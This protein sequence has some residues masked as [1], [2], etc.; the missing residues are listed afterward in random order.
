MQLVQPHRP[1]PV[2]PFFSNPRPRP[3]GGSG[4]LR[5]SAGALTALPNQA[6]S[7]LVMVGQAEPAGVTR[8]LLQGSDTVQ[9]SVIFGRRITLCH[10]MDLLI[11]L[12]VGVGVC[13]CVH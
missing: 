1:L 11:P 6:V 2:L 4:V 10:E 5:P 8:R 12:R 3:E 13:A 7:H 9:S